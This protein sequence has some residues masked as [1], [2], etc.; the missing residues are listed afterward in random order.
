MSKILLRHG[1]SKMIKP[2]E[3]TAG[4]KQLC[5]LKL[6]DAIRETVD[7]TP[8]ILTLP[9]KEHL[10]YDAFKT[11][12]PVSNIVCLELDREIAATLNAQGI[13]T[14]NVDTTTYLKAYQPWQSPFDAIFLDYYS[15]L[16]ESV[17]DDLRTVAAHSNVFG[18]GWSVLGLTLQ[19]AIRFDKSGIEGRIDQG[20]RTRQNEEIACDINTVAGFIE[21]E[22][23]HNFRVKLWHKVE[24]RASAESAS[25][26]F[27]IFL[28]KRTS[29]IQD[30]RKTSRS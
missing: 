6:V 22:I 2:F 26:W 12:F 28:L 8:R 30:R 18:A 27:M 13:T 4:P 3:T 5:R 9:S 11:A 29:Y 7:R 25:M 19:K 14:E 15:F 21:C 23:F 24:Y 17:I 20:L 10:C 1:D 16:T